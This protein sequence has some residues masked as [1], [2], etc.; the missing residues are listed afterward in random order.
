M[1]KHACKRSSQACIHTTVCNLPSCAQ[2]VLLLMCTCISAWQET[3]PRRVQVRTVLSSLSGMHGWH[4]P[5][6]ARH[7]PIGV[8]VPVARADHPGHAAAARPAH[9]CIQQP[10]ENE[11]RYGEPQSAIV[12]ET[13][14]SCV[15]RTLLNMLD[16][17]N[18]TS[19]AWC[20]SACA[21][22]MYLRLRKWI[23]S[24][25]TACTLHIYLLQPLFGLHGQQLQNFLP[26]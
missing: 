14:T 12:E 20:I 15:R 22:F 3:G 23:C 1:H 11:N 18:D 6:L 26:A 19:V 21:S 9:K 17:V 16:A 2:V 10:P 7:D 25:L 8:H 13:F 4:V 24:V 5:N